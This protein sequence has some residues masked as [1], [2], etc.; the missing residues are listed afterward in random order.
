M[1]PLVFTLGPITP[2][3]RRVAR[4]A[5]HLYRVSVGC[6]RDLVAGSAIL[7]ERRQ[8]RRLGLL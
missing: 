5:P 3:R 7:A 8:L 2:E 1:T 4:L 6:R